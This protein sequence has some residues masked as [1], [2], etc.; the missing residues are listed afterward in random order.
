M[1]FVNNYG[2][3]DEEEN[4]VHDNNATKPTSKSMVINAAPDT[5]FDDVASSGLYMAS[6]ATELTVNVPY[7][8][9][10]RPSYGPQNPFSTQKLATQNIIT[11]HVETQAISEVDFRTQHRT[12]ETYGYA[13]D[14]SLGGTNLAGQAGEGMMGTGYVGNLARAADLGGASIHD[15]L[16]QHLRPNKDV[17]KRRE[18]KGDSGVLEGENAYKGPWAGYEFDRKEPET[19]AVEVPEEEQEEVKAVPA[20]PAKAAAAAATPPKKK[21]AREE[22]GNETTIFHGESETDYLG[23]TYM[24]V[25][26]DL[27]INLLGEPGTQ[28][29]FIPKRCI[30]TWDAHPQG[31]SAVRLLPK[32]GHLVLSAGMDNKLKI[33]DF[34]HN[35]SLLRTIM[36]HTKAIRDIA[37]NNDGRR[38]LSASYD[39]YIKLWDTETGQC[40]RSF[41]TGKIPYCVT[42]NPAGNKQHIFLAGCSDKKIVQ[43]DTRSGDITQEY[44]QH[45]G[46]VNSITFVDDN[47]R[48][49]TT[50]DDKT[51]RAWEFDIPVVIKYIAE[52]DMHSMPAVTLHPSTKWLACQSLDNQILIYGARDRFRMNRKKRFAGHLVAGY[53]CKPGF[54]PD[55][56]FLSSGDSNGNVWTWD[57]KSCKILKKFKAHEKVVMN[58]EWHPHETSK[59]VTCSW[60]GKVKLWD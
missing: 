3:S 32:S 53:A 11:G 43:F 21:H 46:P 36:G 31:V 1:D 13:R 28:N 20:V 4:I 8:D 58:T 34:Y 25:P 55:G 41:S 15:R 33:F 51:M 37:F 39:R 57:W 56:R 10:T 18:K 52:P 26:Q 23:R 40:V 7:D 50:S 35:R 45:L 9:M 12:F 48:F 19:A 22:P 27:D 60:D 5:G 38:F 24:A 2:S 59:M 49:I 29:C 14:P 16:P 54:S 17:R 44:D 42:F 6:T 30:H 47:R